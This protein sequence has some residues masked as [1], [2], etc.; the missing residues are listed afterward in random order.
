MKKR[1]GPSLSQEKR[2]LKRCPFCHGTGLVRPMFHEMPCDHCHASGVVCKETG[3]SLQIHDLVLQMRIRLND[4][5]KELADLR[6]RLA[7]L[8]KENDGWGY[9]AGGQ[10]YHGD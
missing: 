10:R 6:Q 4:R 7:A 3:Q 8:S 2:L 1:C 5:E 9:G